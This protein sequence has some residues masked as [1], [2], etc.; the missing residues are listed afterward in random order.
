MTYHP[1]SGLWDDNIHHLSK[2]LCLLV[3]LIS[4]DISFFC[5]FFL[6]TV[7]AFCPSASTPLFGKPP[8]LQGCM[9]ITQH[10]RNSLLISAHN[11]PMQRTPYALS[12]HTHTHTHRHT[13]THKTQAT[14]WGLVLRCNF[15]S[16]KIGFL[17]CCCHDNVPWPGA[18]WWRVMRCHDTAVGYQ[19]PLT[20]RASENTGTM[21]NKGTQ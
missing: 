12:T 16:I 20:L 18:A 10:E 15:L 4:M 8:S 17:S 2:S 3:T 14:P 19:W 5:F 13:P 7:I 21:G 11:L 1:N 6:F 9:D